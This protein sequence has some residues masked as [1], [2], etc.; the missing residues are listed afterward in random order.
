MKENK[1]I[2]KVDSLFRQALEG[3]SPPPPPGVWNKI[4]LQLGRGGGSPL[5]LFKGYKGLI[6]LSVVLVSAVALFI[7]NSDS[8][9]TEELPAKP[10][11]T[12]SIVDPKPNRT[13]A[14]KQENTAPDSINAESEYPQISEKQTKQKQQSNIEVESE[15]QKTLEISAGNQH[16]GSKIKKE[17]NILSTSGINMPD[18]ESNKT[19]ETPDFKTGTF[20]R[21]ADLP[22]QSVSEGPEKVI[23]QELSYGE[24]NVSSDILPLKNSIPEIVSAEN[25]PGSTQPTESGFSG[26]SKPPLPAAPDGSKPLLTGINPFQ[27][28]FGLSGSFGKVMA[29]GLNTN[30]FYSV[31][32]VI[33][34]TH[35]NSDFGVETGFGYSSFRDEGAFTFEYFRRDTTGYTG[36]SLFNSID[37]SYLI[38][39]T[40][41]TTDTHSYKD[42]TSQASVTYIRIPLHFTKKIVSFS[43]F[44]IGIKTGPSLN[45]LIANRETQPENPDPGANLIG[46]KN[47][48]YQKLSTSWQ[49]M[50]AP[51]LS[52]NINRRFVFRV[53]PS[54]VFYLNNLYKPDS[55]PSGKPWGIGA[56][57]GLLYN[58]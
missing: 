43:K 13:A 17:G 28:Y 46:I 44:D 37:S 21:I 30:I 53:E 11:T 18:V 3:Y 47:N 39:F 15:H 35:K 58:F 31:D 32:A 1:D 48:S 23:T 41:Q 38:I 16:G 14:I 56:S 57:A 45:L 29:I 9:I 26:G 34:I 36:H 25:I 5:S 50:V 54:V 52:W 19:V 20:N 55:R 8:S 24:T 40:P 51:Q 2:H 10:K 33:G 42:T 12:E 4:R 7:Y 22:E 49:W 27:Y 6:A